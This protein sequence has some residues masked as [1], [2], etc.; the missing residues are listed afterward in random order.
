M[1]SQAA[2]DKSSE[3][4]YLILSHNIELLTANSKRNEKASKMKETGCDTQDLCEDNTFN[5]KDIKRKYINNLISWSFLKKISDMFQWPLGC[6]GNLI[7]NSSIHGKATKVAIDVNCYDKKVYDRLTQANANTDLSAYK[8]ADS[9]LEAYNDYSEKQIVYSIKDN[10]KGIPVEKFN[11]IMFSFGTKEDNTM[12]ANLKQDYFYR[13]GVT[14]KA[15][16]VRLANGVFILSKTENELSI[17]LICHNL[18]TKLNTDLILTPI[19]NYN[20][21]DGNY[22]F[23]SQF[24]LQSANLIINEIKFLFYDIDEVF[25]YANTFTTGTHI[26]LYDL[27]QLSKDPNRIN[28]LDN[29]EL[30]VDLDSKD[31]IYNLFYL[32]TN[33][34]DT[35]DASLKT[36]LQHLYIRHDLCEIYLFGKKISE[37]I[38]LVSL[39]N[40][41]KQIEDKSIDV[42]NNSNFS[43][44][45][46]ENREIN[47]VVID[48]EMY[49]GALVRDD[50]MKIINLQI[51]PDKIPK[52]I[53]LYLNGRLICPLNQRKFGDV[54]SY[55]KQQSK[56]KD[57]NWIGY[58]ELPVSMFD[59][60]GN[61]TEFKEQTMYA[62][63]YSKFM[64]LIK[65]I[66]KEQ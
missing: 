5:F 37:Q 27:K 50:R 61:K 49:K 40:N 14:M 4:D 55:V 54:A 58:I 36:Y 52:G 9:S 62:Y 12:N 53:Y 63:F 23:K 38:Q 20:I 47:Y 35:I 2:L 48:S 16:C 31:I 13:M 43:I 65:K 64:N 51:N 15:S 44:V 66:N 19:V 18:Q 21:K 17:G 28:C 59:L 7:D 45:K 29:F 42:I 1:S 33:N 41:Y 10:G 60:I 57:N 22:E 56:K 26:F 8:K 3:Q 6:F 46:R 24:S 34:K 11:Q 32:Q 39:Y 25:Q 30:S